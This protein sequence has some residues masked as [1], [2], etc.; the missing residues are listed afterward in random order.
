MVGLGISRRVAEV[1][2]FAESEGRFRSALCTSHFVRF[3][4]CDLS[5]FS[6]QILGHSGDEGLLDFWGELK[7]GLEAGAFFD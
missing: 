1:A 6:P 5:P 2:E 7:V 3:G 4:A